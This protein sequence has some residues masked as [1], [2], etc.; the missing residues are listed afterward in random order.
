MQIHQIK[1]KIKTATSFINNPKKMLYPAAQN[2]FFKWIP[3]K[4]FL[5]IL[6][7]AELDRRLD[8]NDPTLFSEK[9]QWLKLH[10][11][12]PNYTYLVDK[13]LVKSI[14]STKIGS[15]YIIPTLKYWDSV[16]EI[17]FD[18]LPNSFVIK[19]NHDSGG[20]FICKDKRTQDISLL[21]KRIMIRFERNAYYSGREWP[22]KNISKR[23]I[24]EELLNDPNHYDLI[25]YK[26]Y[27]F[28][29][30]PRYCQVI[31]NRSTN[32]TIDFYDMEWRYQPFTG[33]G[34]NSKQGDPIDKPLRFETM[35]NMAE[36][37]AEGTMF[38][39]I[40]LYNIDGKIYFGEYTL[41]P[42]SGFGRFTPDEWNIKLGDMIHIKE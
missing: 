3:D 25:D 7:W 18:C 23:I 2:G 12:N 34:I 17:D 28:N 5:K 39:R 19:C 9:I 36:K 24:A 41:Y 20:I 15:E 30:I 4:Y 16:E 27:C 1:T 42:K 31:Q 22:Y 29:G 10:D 11:R 33:L 32:E 6:Y 8:L 26:F 38:V 14:V 35:K 37:L 13:F 21:K 40:D